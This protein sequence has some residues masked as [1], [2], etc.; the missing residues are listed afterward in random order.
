[1]Q[2]RVDCQCPP[3]APYIEKPLSGLQRELPADVMQLRLLRGVQIDAG[4]LEIRAGIHHGPIQPER[5]KIVRHV[6]VKMNRIPIFRPV[7][8]L[9]RAPVG[10]GAVRALRPPVGVQRP[11]AQ[12]A[13]RRANLLAH[14]HLHGLQ[15]LP[16]GE[17]REKIAFDVQILRKVRLSQPERISSQHGGTNHFGFRNT[18]AKEHSRDPVCGAPT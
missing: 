16:E 8:R 13:G 1:M 4:V 6:I 9:D 14:R 18:R 10:Y 12:R 17:R 3:A 15:M 5:I 7:V 11:Q 2:R